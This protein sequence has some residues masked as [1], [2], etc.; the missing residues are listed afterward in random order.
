MTNLN[1]HLTNFLNCTSYQF[2]KNFI[3]LDKEVGSECFLGSI[4]YRK[5]KMALYPNII[6]KTVLQW[7]NCLCLFSKVQDFFFTNIYQKLFRQRW[8]TRHRKSILQLLPFS[9]ATPH[10]WCHNEN[11]KSY[12][13]LPERASCNWLPLWYMCATLHFIMKISDSRNCQQNTLYI[14]VSILAIK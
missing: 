3:Q 12:L 4:I 9:F 6:N 8:Q 14:K 10:S 11:N 7:E 1:I 5:T 13:N 2:L